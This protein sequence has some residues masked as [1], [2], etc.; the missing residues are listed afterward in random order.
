MTQAVDAAAARQSDERER[1]GVAV[2]EAE[3]NACTD[4][5]PMLRFL[6]GKAS[7][8]KLRLFAVGCCRRIWRLLRDERSQRAVEVAEQFA[9]GLTSDE[10]LRGA[11]LDAH[12]PTT[13]A[14]PDW[15]SSRFQAQ[16]ASAAFAARA[17]ELCTELDSPAVTAATAAAV[18]TTAYA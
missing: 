9:E 17:A 5:A 14:A 3:W 16:Y 11:G 6:V 8:R 12:L 10:H 15:A 4:P 2:T 1:E 18:A 7:D 13:T